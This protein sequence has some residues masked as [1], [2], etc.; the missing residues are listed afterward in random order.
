[1]CG[2]AGIFAYRGSAAPADV[3]ELRRM[4][5]FMQRRG[6][7]ASGEWL[8][9]DR[10]VAL[11]HRRLSIID[12]SDRASQPM[13]NADG[14][15]LISFNGEIY[16]YRTLREQLIA[17]GHSFRTT[18][19]TEVILNLYAEYGEALVDHLRGMFAFALWDARERA[20]LLARDPYGIKPLYYADDGA[21][22]RFA[23]QVKALMAGGG[24][25][26]GVD[27]AA[28]VGFMLFGSVPEPWTWQRSV[29]SVRAGEVMRWQDGR[30]SR[31]RTF[32]S[33]SEAWASAARQ[34][35]SLEPADLQ[36]AVREAL[37]DS[38]THHQIADVP[39]A[40]FLS[41][42]ID[43]G[44]LLGMMA[45]V[46]RAP[47]QALT[48]RFDEFVDQPQDETQ[49]AAEVARC[50]GAR[51]VART[52]AESEF[53]TDLPA[54]LHAMDQPSIDGINTWFV[55]KAAH[56]R[57]LKVAVSGLGG[58]ELFGGY[59]S[60]RDAERWGPWL[61]PASS[62]PGLPIVFR[63]SVRRLL[64]HLPRASPK[65]ASVLEYGGTGSGT[66]F[67]RRALFMPWE[68]E[69][70]LPADVVHAGLA[71]LEPIEHTASQLAHD[72]THPFASV[73][74]LE[75]SLYMRNQLLRD[76]DWASMAWSIEVR[77]PLVDRVLLAALASLIV[78]RAGDKRLLAQAARPALPA[79]VCS[80]PKTGFSTP[81]AKW[82]AA[83]R[84]FGRWRDVQSLNRADCHWSRRLAYDL[85]RM[86]AESASATP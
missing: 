10:R 35:R 3:E 29:R 25:A 4:R 7:D 44:A 49:V 73:A 17:K 51:H 52:V 31:S 55:S 1:M 26:R 42:G 67:L 54:I 41:A 13:A 84:E 57:G 69:A 21:T 83:S 43:S 70:V 72:L 86:N 36:H 81:I 62:V 80:R 12:L 64:P 77:V 34:P 78:G 38:V 63:E 20:L 30:E 15:V 48:L 76:A 37:L 19:D 79:A 22:L 40:V 68:L 27:P 33:V 18:S 9:E 32:L 66:Y 23:S 8:S 50:Y 11:G 74:A 5:D 2:I 71:A 65:L 6:P 14:S 45:E 58:D 75:A 47:V 39:V 59:P 85:A 82:L 53:Q 60:F 46:S 16:N 56:E 61:R 28:Q 24:V